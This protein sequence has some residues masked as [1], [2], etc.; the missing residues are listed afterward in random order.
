MNYT[1][2]LVL[3]VLACLAICSVQ[4]DNFSDVVTQLARFQ[5]PQTGGFGNTSPV[6]TSLQATS[7]ALFLSQLYG[8]STK[9]NT[10]Y[11]HEFLEGHRTQSNGFASASGKPADIE[12]TLYSVLSYKYL[13]T[14]VPNVESVVKFILSLVDDSGL[15]KDRVG[16]QPSLRASFQAVATLNALDLVKELPV[17]QANKLSALLQSSI[18]HE[19]A[20]S[21]FEYPGVPSLHATFYGLY[22]LQSFEAASAFSNLNA[23][24]AFVLNQQLVNGGFAAELNGQEADYESTYFALATLELMERIT[25]EEDDLVSEIQLQQFV[26]F[27]RRVPGNLHEITLSHKSLALTQLVS[28]VFKV[29]IEYGVPVKSNKIV[30][31]TVIRP[32]VLVRAFSGPSH[33]GF[34]AT[35]TY[36]LEDGSAKSFDLEWDHDKQRYIS[37]ESIQTAGYTGSL[38]FQFDLGLNVFG[39]SELVLTQTAEKAIGYGINVIATATHTTGR[40]I[41]VGDVVSAGTQF[42]FDTRLFNKTTQSIRSG[43]F[44]VEFTVQDSSKNVVYKETLDGRGNTEPFT[45]SYNLQ[46]T[47]YPPGEFTF[48]F[49]VIRTDGTL[50]SS[51]TLQYELSVPL[52]ASDIRF[53]SQYEAPELTLGSQLQ[54]TIVPATLSDASPH[55]LS[56]ATQPRQFFMDIVSRSNGVVLQSIAGVSKGESVTFEYTVPS[57]FEGLGS[58]EVVFRYVSAYGRQVQLENY[59][60]QEG[61][62]YEESSPVVLNVQSDLVVEI[63]EAPTNTNLNYGTEVTFRAKVTDRKTNQL[64]SNVGKRGGLFLTLNHR[65]EARDRTFTS[66]KQAAVSEGD[67][68]LVSWE[69]NPNAVNGESE[70]RLVAEGADGVEVPLVVSGTGK[71]Y[72]LKVNIG[73]DIKESYEVFS[74][75]DYYTSRTAFVVQF[76]LSC[77]GHALKD[78]KLRASVSDSNG[79]VLFTVPVGVSGDQYVASWTT[80]HADSPSGT[81]TVDIYRETDHTR[82]AESDEW[83]QKQLR[84]KQREAELAGTTF[85]EA[86]FLSTLKDVSVQPLFT[87]NIPHSEVKLR[88]LF[89]R[90]EVILGVVVFAGWLYFDRIKLRLSQLH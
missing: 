1:F 89:V 17:G 14:P 59:N 10:L 36:I 35:L 26:Y 45:F 83:K 51:E 82:A 20:I 39:I 44:D 61:E 32:E 6:E 76:G 47:Y 21:R 54:V 81:Y 58:Y 84:A 38:K 57:T 68:F 49:S 15:F 46:S 63:L 41:E 65:D 4:A 70:I 16:G 90:P 7:D 66:A 8:L 22:I 12:S 74:T 86:E 56:A 40:T 64:L 72:S 80:D 48:S 27:L 79:K 55:P 87:V 11:I 42:E 88:G 53:N 18:K 28:D 5:N 50:H 52:V 60:S 33:P 25:L 2:G 37:K 3:A 9:L 19:G 73:G 85:D 62:L 67:E 34:D 29:F 13:E 75:S 71:P 69:I 24:K 31:G 30:Q 23:I 78:V 43:D 77:D